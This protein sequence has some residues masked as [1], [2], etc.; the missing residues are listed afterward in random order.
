MSLTPGTRLGRY[1][2]RSPLGAGGMGEV[3]LAFDPELERTVAIK[4]LRDS[5]QSADR[6]RRF[7][8]EAKAASALNHPNVAQV[9]EIGSVDELRYI[10][11]E[12]V[13]GETLRQRLGHGKMSI[14]DVLSIATQIASAL[15]AAHS[16]GIVHRD[17]KPDNIILRPD[18]YV[19]VL[20]FGLAKLRKS[21]GQSGITM[22][23][24]EPGLVMGTLPYMAPE[25]VG[26]GEV[27]PAA[28]VFS[29]GVVLYE[30][31]AGVRPFEGDTVT[32][33]ATAILS[34]T[35]RP[36]EEMRPDIPPKLAGVISK[37]LAKEI[38]ARYSNAEELLSEL[39]QISRE[40][41]AALNEA[42]PPRL[43]R[44]TLPAWTLVLALIVL[45]L[46]AAAFYFRRAN[47]AAQRRA[48][49]D[50]ASRAEALLSQG[51]YPEAYELASAAARTLPDDARLLSVISR[52]SVPIGFDSNP[53]GAIVSLRR[54]GGPADETS[55]GTTPLSIAHLPRGDYV[56]TF[57]KAGYAPAMRPLPLAP[58]VVH[59]FEAPRQAGDL[60]VT[61][62]PSA[63]VP[64]EMVFVAGGDYRLSGFDRLTDRAVKLDDFFIDRY[65]V[66]NR[67]FSE[68][69]RGGGYH[70]RAFWKHPFVDGTKTLSFEV[71]MNRFR[72]STGL[73]GPRSWTG[74]APPSGHENHPVTDITWYEAAAFAEWKGKSLP[75]VFQWEKAARNPLKGALGSSF[76]W[77]VLAEGTDATTR[78]NFLGKG[79]LPVDSMPFGISP[80]GA[81]NMAGNVS[82][83]CRNPIDPGFAVRGG[84]WNDAV[85]AFG[86]TAAIPGLF[87]SSTVGFR[88]AKPA[89][90]DGGGQNDQGAFAINA[91]GLV[92][93]YHPVDDR[94]FADIR[95]RYTYTNTP[96][97]SKIVESVDTPDW[98][99]EKIEYIVAGRTVPAYLYLPNGFPRPLQVVH[100]AP[101]GDV[102]NGFRTLPASIEATL[103]PIIRGGRA[104]FSV[105]LEGY[106][107]RPRPATSVEPDSRSAEY[108][109]YTVTQVTELRRGLDY[110]ETRPD[111][112][113]SRIT[114]LGPSAGSW[115]GVLIAA[116]ESRYRSVA[117]VGTHISPN[118]VADAPAANRINF[119]PHISGPTLMLQGRYDESAPLKSQAEPLFKLLREPKRLEIYEGSHAPTAAV[120]IPA[121]TKWF[122]ET[123]GPVAQ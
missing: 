20:D 42:E 102:A 8:Q 88:C 76:P 108:V 72:D 62:V 4:V 121:L 23:K 114:F 45:A 94:T 122:D 87:S 5:D 77:G 51:A 71:A 98:R 107:E 38:S 35:P 90:S 9:Y 27:T 106:T 32:Q 55:I 7:I 79:T 29:T 40:T 100:F 119:A 74:G 83:W 104:V 70:N 15:G 21:E 24:T 34:S 63:K 80:W 69:I 120:L 49:G 44:R 30:M 56:I 93:Q 64:A 81:Y 117:F 105:V 3:Y 58:I 101:A 85:Y 14:D 46:A 60:R 59:G 67:D 47:E 97:A 91:S 86:R 1:E 11:M 116:L 99:R 10:V 28:D 66:S 75:T 13:E 109:D 113:H 16:A 111:I 39:R 12:V 112:D 36:L 33:V 17:V 25:Q 31:I 50:S 78:A 103:A 61:L 37:S 26:G 68:F 18:G 118:E 65:E 2:V 52:A 123:M 57:R 82:E 48:A 54:F 53:P 6:A 22:L 84:S 95:A 92:P 110:L 43:R 41:N 96:L 73:P 19:K 89:G 115:A